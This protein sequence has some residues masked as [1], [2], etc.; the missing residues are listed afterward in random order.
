MSDFDFSQF[1]PGASGIDALFETEPALVTPV[2]PNRVR[3]A[4]IRD[5]T[6]F[7]RVASDMLVHKSNRDLWAMKQ[8]DDGSYFIERLYNDN[9]QPLKG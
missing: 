2:N 5:L 3:V 8:D 7:A 9:G 6:P 1:Q 4:S